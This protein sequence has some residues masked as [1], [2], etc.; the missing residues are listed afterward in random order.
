MA[1]KAAEAEE[2]FGDDDTLVD[3]SE[4]S[5]R[6]SHT[7]LALALRTPPW[8]RT[9]SP[10]PPSPKRRRCLLREVS[11]ASS[12]QAYSESQP[13]PNIHEDHTQY[14]WNDVEG[15]VRVKQGCMPEGCHDM[16][17]GQRGFVRKHRT[18]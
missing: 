8:R 2:I 5:T 10:K 16:E 4:N 6:V 13:Q 18:E 9:E 3:A 14:Y 11:S 17:F 15:G 1:N 7:T 12:T